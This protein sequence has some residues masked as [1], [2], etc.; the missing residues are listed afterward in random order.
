[1]KKVFV[2]LA[3]ICSVTSYSAADIELK[4]VDEVQILTAV[5][6]EAEA[7]KIDL[8]STFIDELVKVEM[9]KFPANVTFISPVQSF[10]SKNHLT[11]LIVVQVGEPQP[12]SNVRPF[13]VRFIVTED[14]ILPRH[15]NIPEEI[16]SYETTTEP[17]LIVGK[18]TKIVED[19]L[20]AAMTSFFSQLAK[21]K[22]EP[23]AAI[24]DA[25]WAQFAKDNPGIDGPKLWSTV[26]ETVQN[27]PQLKTRDEQLAAAKSIFNKMVAAEKIKRSK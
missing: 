4:T 22:P 8:T 19:E 7:K 23:D 3:L 10:T 9:V 2:A 11:V 14:A 25:Y 18:N 5:F 16:T 6:P 21:D 13:H 27:D 1:M 17:K 12:A 20:N 15:G 26:T 24:H